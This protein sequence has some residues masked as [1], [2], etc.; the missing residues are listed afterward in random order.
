LRDLKLMCGR[1]QIL[2]C[3]GRNQINVRTTQK[4]K[5]TTLYRIDKKNNICIYVV[6]IK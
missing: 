4:E 6:C 2:K 3:K 1:E 5:C